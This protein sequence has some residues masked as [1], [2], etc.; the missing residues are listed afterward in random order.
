MRKPVII[1]LGVGFFAVLSLSVGTFYQKKNAWV[2]KQV[3]TEGFDGSSEGAAARLK[4]YE[5]ENKELRER[6]LSP[7]PD[8]GRLAYYQHKFISDLTEIEDEDYTSLV[9]KEKERKQIVF[10]G[11]FRLS[12]FEWLNDEEMAIYR[13]CGTECMVAYHIDLLKNETHRLSLGVGYTWSPDRKYVLAYHVALQPGVTIGDR[14]G[15]PVFTL[16]RNS[17]KNKSGYSPH[18]A[19]WSPDS[20]KLALII[21][22]DN[23][24]R[25]EALIF[26]AREKFKLIRQKDLESDKFSD[27]TWASHRTVAY[28]DGGKRTTLGLY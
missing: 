17:P 1:G 20:S 2:A 9:V 16:R 22:K 7:S 14:L 11:N 4:I 6:T 5:Q 27:L 12:Y 26:D 8:G 25:L 13:D 10:T 21:H 3:E 28:T 24:A 18:R 15:Q 19:V 23:E